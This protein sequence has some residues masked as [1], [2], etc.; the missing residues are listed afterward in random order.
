M[1]NDSPAK[2][3]VDIDLSSLRVSGPAGGRAGSGQRT[4]GA[5]PWLAGRWGAAVGRAAGAAAPLSACAGWCG[6][7]ANLRRP[8]APGPPHDP[9]APGDGWSA[10][11]PSPLTVTF[12]SQVQ[13]ILL[14][15]PPGVAGIT[16]MCRHTQLIFVSFVETGFHHVGQA[17]LE[18]Q[19]SNSRPQSLTVT[20]AE[21]QWHDLSS[22]QPLPPG[23]KVLLCPQ[24]GVQWCSLHS[25]QPLPPGF[26][27][28]SYLSLPSICDYRHWSAMAQSIATSGWHT[29][30]NLWFQGSSNSPASASQCLLLP[31]LECSGMILAHCNLR[32]PDS[33]EM[34]FC[35][36]GRAG[37]ELLASSDPPSLALQSA[38]ITASN[39]FR[40]CCLGWSAVV[41][42]QLTATSAPWVQAILLPQPPEPH[43]TLSL[44]LQY[45]GAMSAHCSL[46]LSGSGDSCASS[47]VVGITGVCYH[48]WLIF[49]FLVEM[50]FH[51]VGQAD[52][53]FLTSA[54]IDDNHCGVLEKTADP[55]SGRLSGNSCVWRPQEGRME[56]HSIAQWCTLS[57]LQPLVSQVQTGFHHIG[58]AG[59][60][61]LKM[62]SCS[63]TQPG[64]QWCNLG[65][66]QPLPYRF[67]QFF[68]LSLLSG[69][70]YKYVPPYLASFC[71]FSTDRFHHVG[72][73]GLK[74]L[75]SSDPPT[76]ASQSARIIGMSHCTW[77][78]LT[79]LVE[80]GSL[81]VGQA[82]LEHLTLGDLPTLASL[83][84]GIT[85]VRECHHLGQAG[86]ELLTL[87]DPPSSV[88][89]SA[90][91]T[92][93]LHSVAQAGMQWCNLCSLQPPPSGFIRFSCLSLLSDW[94]YRWSLALSSRLACSGAISVHC[95]LHLP[96][97]SDSL[98]SVSQV[99]G[100]TGVHHY[101]QLIFVFFNRDRVS[102]YVGQAGLKLWISGDLPASA[103]QSAGIADSLTLLL[104]MECSGSVMAHCSM[105]LLGTGDPSTSAA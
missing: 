44:K 60:E 4:A 87:G 35:H 67:E 11:A 14:P 98:A 8:H 69:W 58:Q 91:V 43:L 61:L 27:R 79:L 65:S 28:F 104:M 53:E 2:S 59:F 84:A 45:S 95:N 7:G 63:A 102:L 51:H 88:Y 29:H 75:S 62:E 31:R 26:K 18:L 90:G 92:G 100:T 30:C 52:L 101:A 83:S 39:E 96:G 46:H 47:R 42:S 24:A 85:V 6:A 82:G 48:T 23:F 97:S 50:G 12:A 3:L 19:A 17:G 76:S 54:K 21:M 73:A 89:Q 71:I 40:S 81:H 55:D 15:Q 36:V 68:C 32:L 20:W 94:D 41:R 34:G 33:I 5:A 64:V 37:L 74:L 105:D 99:A 9:R 16:G 70:D 103:S 10:V 78:I 38:G 1:A 57:S 49:V 25:L 93:S 56:S 80:T 86:L 22:L 77:L 72:K 13:V 66:L